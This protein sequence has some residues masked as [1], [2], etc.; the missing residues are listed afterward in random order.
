[1]SSW[2]FYA[3]RRSHFNHMAE[4]TIAQKLLVAAGK[5]SASGKPT[6][7]A[8]DIVVKAHELYGE[9]FALKGYPQ[10]PDSNKV[11][12]QLMGKSA[13]LFVRGWLEKVGTKLYL[14]TPKGVA[15]LNAIDADGSHERSLHV[16]H[17][18]EAEYGRILTSD[19][20]TLF[21]DG[22][23]EGIIFYQFCRFAGLSAGDK[24][25][26]VENRLSCLTHSVK[27]IVKL[28]ESGQRLNIHFRKRNYSFTPDDLRSV[29]ALYKFLLEKFQPQ[30]D[31]WK[32]NVLG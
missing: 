13:P 20:Y 3:N 31:E 17:I 11:Y 12:T 1:M 24:W 5:L 26:T 7:S 8:E 4:L 9:E 30:L 28:G 2:K 22:Q 15:D 16:E 21:C 6:F 14:L 18:L 10:V 19:V 25:Q 32:K 23:Q 27:E 29:G